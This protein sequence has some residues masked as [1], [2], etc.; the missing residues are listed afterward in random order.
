MADKEFFL[1]NKPGKFNDFVFIL[2]PKNKGQAVVFEGIAYDFYPT[3][4]FEYT[5]IRKL[6][7]RF[8]TS[9]PEFSCVFYDCAA[10]H[11]S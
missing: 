1:L 10:G 9:I 3:V 8:V 7:D 6:P 4:Y 11:S 2:Y 5:D